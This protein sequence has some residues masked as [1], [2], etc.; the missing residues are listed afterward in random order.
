MISNTV[1]LIL[2]SIFFLATLYGMRDLSFM[3]WDGTPA[4]A[5][6]MGCLKHWTAREVPKFYS[7]FNF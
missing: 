2:N 5:L 7:S 6:G 4:P 3:T 1:Q